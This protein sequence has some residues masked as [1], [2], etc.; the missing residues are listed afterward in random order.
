MYTLIITTLCHVYTNNHNWGYYPNINIPNSGFTDTNHHCHTTSVKLSYS[1]ICKRASSPSN[2]TVTAVQSSKS[3]NT[4]I[5]KVSD[6]HAKHIA[7]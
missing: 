6:Y 7:R 1:S 4:P 5:T 2:N 3:A